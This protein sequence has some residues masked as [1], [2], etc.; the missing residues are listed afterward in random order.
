VPFE[1]LGS[2]REHW[3][4]RILAHCGLP[5]EP[6]V[7]APHENRRPVATAAMQVRQ[8]INR[9]GVGSAEAYRPF[10]E[11]FIEDYYGRS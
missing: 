10:L 8:P 5:D 9:A 7:F 11:P 4:R 1:A 6:Q 2:E 3:I